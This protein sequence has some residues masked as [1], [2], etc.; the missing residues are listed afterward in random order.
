VIR[1][2]ATALLAAWILAAVAAAAPAP[3]GTVVFVRFSARTGHPQ[4]ATLVLG[5][6]AQVVAL[7][8]AA[9]AGPA[10]A[11]GSGRIAFAGGANLPGRPDFTGPSH[12]WVAQ[13]D[14]RGA[15]AAT[16]GDV[17]DGA[18]AWS[19]GGR[20]LVFVRSAG[21]GHGS[22]LWTVGAAGEGLHRLTRGAVDLEPSWSSGGRIAF[23]RIDPAT[24][25]S[26]VWVTDARGSTPRRMLAGR[27]GLTDPQ[28]SPDGRRLAV[29]DGRAI[30]VARADGSA[31][32]L[33]VRL[34]S[35][36]GGTI[37]DPQ[38]AWSPDSRRLVFVG[39][40]SGS[41]G[42]SD[43]LVVAVEGGRSRR[44]MRSPGLDTDPAWRG[45]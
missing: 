32:H 15:R 25:Q 34:P 44:I 8:V 18:P 28:W 2:C 29:G 10:L 31:F 14:G 13:P 22:S 1:R 21:T 41:A 12:I 5:G 17:S 38:P 16:H 42:R 35:G 23:V 6:R 30:Y 39:L 3:T 19:P 11:R 26:G 20:R 24:Y 43:L 9:V 33:L 27:R 37:A 7:P 4:L 36:P 45:P 40:R